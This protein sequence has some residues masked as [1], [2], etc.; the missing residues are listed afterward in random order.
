MDS[1]LKLLHEIIASQIIIIARLK[2][3]IAE[4]ER[5]LGLNSSNSSKPPS[6]D[7]L[8]KPP[9]VMSLREKGKNPSGGQAGHQGTTLKMVETPDEIIPHL[10]IKCDGCGQGIASD[11]PILAEKRQ[12]FDIPPPKIIVTEHRVFRHICAC[13]H[14]TRGEFPPEVTHSTQ[15]GARIQAAITYLNVAQL[16]PEDRLQEVMNDL[17]GV[18]PATATIAAI[19]NR[20]AASFTPVCVAIEQKLQQAP[21]KHLDET[22]FRVACK[23]QWLH[24]MS[25]DALTHYRIDEKRGKMPENLTK[26]VVHDHWKPYFTLKN[27][28]HALC[29]AHILRELK[30]VFEKDNERWAKRFSKLLLMFKTL[31]EKAISE[32]ETSIKSEIFERLSLIYDTIVTRAIKF[33]ENLPPFDPLIASKRGRKKRRIA[34]NLLLRLQGFKAEIL[35]FSTDFTVPFTNNQAEQDIRMMK[36]RQK[37]SGSFRTSEGAKT[38]V[39]LRAIISTARKNH[40]KILE[41]LS[42][43]PKM[44][45]VKITLV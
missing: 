35:R 28:T 37:I 20:K 43:C 12:V 15:Y 22:G 27:V 21:L 13:G 7:G 10:P 39:T 1:S 9:R 34:H 2:A 45:N 18:K 17:F 16:L 30:A 6:S 38:F 23:T 5:M 40:W 29:N 3:R 19:V 36:V 14:Q 8:K 42:Q 33:H 11:A 41:T 4:L 25:N 31:K 26:T 32:G 24:S 44:M